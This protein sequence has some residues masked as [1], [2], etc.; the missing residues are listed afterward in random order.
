MQTLYPIVS[1]IEPGILNHPEHKMM[2][3][4][5]IAVISTLSR[6]ILTTNQYYNNALAF[7]IGHTNNYHSSLRSS[8]TM[9]TRQIKSFA[10]HS[11]QYNIERDADFG[12]IL[13]GG[14]RY[15]MVEL[16]DSMIDTTIFVGNLCEVRF[17][18]QKSVHNTVTQ[19]T[20]FEFIIFLPFVS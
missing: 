16:P 14:Q 7:Q 20:V 9:S 17:K 5:S 3:K 1:A 8:A 19:L 18:I 12:E 15:E 4:K 13:A 10:L 6:I 2:K 11:Y